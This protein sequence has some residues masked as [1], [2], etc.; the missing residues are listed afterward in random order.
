[1]NPYRN[2]GRGDRSLLIVA[3][4]YHVTAVDLATGREVWR[5]ALSGGGTGAVDLAIHDRL[6]VACASGARVSALDYATGAVRWSADTTGV[7]GRA[8]ILVDAGRILVAKDGYLDC[9]D[10][11]GNSV[12]KQELSGLGH[13][14]AALGLPG[15][16]RQADAG[17][18]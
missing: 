1:M 18:P 10:E 9:F 11:A 7:E 14:V 16:V 8:T 4:G 13:G 3:M 17:E 12:W 2:E 15:N 6:V 5:H